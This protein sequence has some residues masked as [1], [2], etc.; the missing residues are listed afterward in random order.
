MFQYLK[1]KKTVLGIL[2]PG[3]SSLPPRFFIAALFQFVARFARV[4]FEDSNRNRFASTAYFA[5]PDYVAFVATFFRFVA[6]FARVRIE[7]SS[8]NRF[9]STAYFA[10]PGFVGGGNNRGGTFWGGICR[11]PIF[12]PYLLE[13]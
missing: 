9:A 1:T 13:K 3:K 11:L 12:R 2:S 8:G 6:R 7:D 10:K 5:K 4:S